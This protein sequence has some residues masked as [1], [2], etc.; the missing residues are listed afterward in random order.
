MA[1][2]YADEHALGLSVFCANVA[3]GRALATG[4][5][6][7]H[8]HQPAA[9]P[10]GF[11][12]ELAT[13]FAPALIQDRLVQT[14]LGSDVT[15]W[16][17]RTPAGRATHV[18]DLQILDNDHRV[19]FAD[20]VRGLVQEVVAGIGNLGMNPLDTSLGALPVVAEFGFAAHLAL[21][22]GQAN[23]VSLEARQRPDNRFF[24]AVPQGC[25]TNYT[26][27][28]PNHCRG[29]VA[30]LCHLALSLD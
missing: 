27:V 12:V 14:R 7:W 23:F 21:S 10:V 18:F 24:L 29:R 15:T 17:S 3:T 9:F 5:G 28:D 16:L 20:G 25:E 2:G 22:L 11:V 8:R 4:I 30:G 26:Q 6:R 13:K 1:A 19:A